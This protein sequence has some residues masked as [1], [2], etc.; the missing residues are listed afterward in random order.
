MLCQRSVR[1]YPIKPPM[2]EPAAASPRP[3][4]EYQQNSPAP[5][6]GTR[7]GSYPLL[8]CLSLLAAGCSTP[9][10]R[11]AYLYSPAL[12][13]TIRDI[14]PFTGD[15]TTGVPAYVDHGEHVLGMAY[16]PFTDHFFIRLF[17]GNQIR[18]IDRPA[19]SIKRSFRAPT[20]PLGGHD[21]AIRSRDRH[22]FFTDP[23]AP[24][25]FET[26]INGELEHYHKLEGLAAPAWG[27]AYDSLQDELL[28]LPA[29][30]SD[31]LI[32][33]SPTGARLGELPLEVPVQGMS[34]AFDAEAREYFASLAD[35]SAIG[36]FD[37]RGRL[38]RRLPRPSPE[39]ETFI[40]VGPRSL[41]RLF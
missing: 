38:L 20:L 15:E 5:R 37:A 18:V 26:D 36:V 39:R 28:I 41:L 35:A 2:K 23:T 22:L 7:R 16:D 40:D 24:A 30:Q 19:A 21:L 33:F 34:L 13:P 29:Q 32:R 8:A 14:D 4:L 9:G 17:P 27:I 6:A 10:P 3:Q 31:R 11:H 25:V 12:G 1:A